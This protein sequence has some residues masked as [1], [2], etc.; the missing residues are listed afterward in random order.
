MLHVINLSRYFM[1][2]SRDDVAI[3][4]PHFSQHTA[5]QQKTQ[6]AKKKEKRH[7][8]CPALPLFIAHLPH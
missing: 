6:K 8:C 2:I 3:G 5:W 4:E 7:R 1:F